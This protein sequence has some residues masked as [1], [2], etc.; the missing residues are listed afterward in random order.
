M[1]IY[2]LRFKEGLP[3]DTNRNLS[4]QV[5]QSHRNGYHVTYPVGEHDVTP[6]DLL[7][8]ATKHVL[9]ID[10]KGQ[11]TYLGIPVDRHSTSI[12][13]TESGSPKVRVGETKVHPISANNEPA[14]IMKPELT[15]DG[16]TQ[17]LLL[18]CLYFSPQ[19]LFSKY[20]TFQPEP[21]R[22]I[23]VDTRALLT[24]VPNQELNETELATALQALD[25]FYKPYSMVALTSVFTALFKYN[26]LELIARD[27]QIKYTLKK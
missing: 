21:R 7:W 5:F 13:Q 9:K 18:L 14:A 23:I 3:I 19:A 2:G 8:P 12:E 24:Q 6:S 1:P 17:I 15:K 25:P 11:G 10:A 22:D 26:H 27:N 20:E 16:Q 4:M